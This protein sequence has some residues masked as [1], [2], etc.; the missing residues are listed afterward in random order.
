MAATTHTLESVAVAG[1]L[2]RAVFSNGASVDMPNAACGDL[3]CVGD[4]VTIKLGRTAD[5]N[6]ECALN[7]RTYHSADNFVMLSCGGLLVK[8]P[9]PRAPI[10]DPC[11]ISLVRGKRRR[12]RS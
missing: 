3:F 8:V 7:G 10:P 12:E 1:S 9:K 4:R 6:A 5:V 2:L 11:V